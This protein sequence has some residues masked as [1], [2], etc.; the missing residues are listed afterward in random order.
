MTWSGSTTDSTERTEMTG[1]GPGNSCHR[2]KER[3]NRNWT[4]GGRKQWQSPVIC[5]AHVVVAGGAL[6]HTETHKDTCTVHLVG[7][8]ASGTAQRLHEG[9]R[10]QP[11]LLAPVN[12]SCRFTVFFLT[13]VHAMCVRTRAHVSLSLSLSL[14]LSRSLFLSLS[15]SPSVCVCRSVCLSAYL[16]SLWIAAST[17]S[18]R[19]STGSPGHVLMIPFTRKRTARWNPSWGADG[20]LYGGGVRTVIDGSSMA[21]PAALWSAHGR[22]GGLRNPAVP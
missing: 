20:K 15:L 6:K 2:A 10:Y 22:S 3:M 17:A 21:E 14:S 13:S 5:N 9:N 7:F 8:T 18:A 4:G 12:I 19:S 1:V 16:S 11:A